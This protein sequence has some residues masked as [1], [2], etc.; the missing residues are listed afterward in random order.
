M[1][2]VSVRGCAAT[3]VVGA[4]LIALSACGAKDDTTGV[5]ATAA[6]TGTATPRDD[7]IHQ[8][9]PDTVKSTGVITAATANDYPPFEFLDES[10][11]LVGADIDFSMALGDIMGVQIKNQVTP[12]SGIV[13][14]LASGRYDVGIS[15]IGDYL[16]RQKSVDFIDYYQ[17]G[18]SFLI[19]AGDPAP[20]TRTDVCGT[21][22][23]VLK[24]TSSESMAEDTGKKCVDGGNKPVNV[25]AFPTQNAAVLALT[26]KRVDSVSGDVA[27][28]G[29]SAKQVGP[30][31]QNVGLTVYDDRPYYGIALPKGS[32][33]FDPFMAAV[34]R[35]FDSGQYKAILDKW[36]IADGAIPAPTKNNGTKD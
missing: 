2:K 9:L 12:F 7:A 35:L 16:S 3:V 5:D 28:N 26:S 34:K 19:R 25:M 14:G 4:T 10:N 30:S 32:P 8:S 18:T 23:A 27:T 21:S 13:T 36:G 11:N 20:K 33:L 15:S 6:D 31:L 29:Y 17:G 1:G 24:G 22:V